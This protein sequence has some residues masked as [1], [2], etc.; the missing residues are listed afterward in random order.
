MIF[1][2]CNARVAGYLFPALLNELV[3]T[4]LYGGTECLLQQKI[5]KKNPTS[6]ILYTMFKSQLTILLK[7]QVAFLLNIIF[8]S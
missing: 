5:E 8:L 4:I 2:T 6:V 3:S 7:M 1:P